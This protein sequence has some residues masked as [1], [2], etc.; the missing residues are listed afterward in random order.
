MSGISKN[1]FMVLSVVC[2]IAL[3]VFLIQLIVL[4]RDS[5]P[6]DIETVV[7]EGS[8]DRDGQNQGGDEDNV[9]SGSITDFVPT[10]TPR[11]PPQG[12]EYILPVDPSTNTMLSIYAAEE[13]F[14]FFENLNDWTFAYK[15]G[16][17][18]SLVISFTGMSPQG[19]GGSDAETFLN[20]ILGEEIAEFKGSY[21]IVDSD[22]TGFNAQ[23]QKDG[24]TYEVW[25]YRLEGND[26]NLA[27]AFCINYEFN[28]QMDDL[29]E[30][31]SSMSIKEG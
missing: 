11:P 1:L 25:L 3:V 27:L 4:N 22:M 29:Y 21:S 15:N 31:L 16:G 18:V 23:A 12:Q 9:G 14:D 2:A 28:T 6:R 19:G 26:L 30:V 10:P 8:G 17:D 24:R 7:S 13:K 20:D 5:E